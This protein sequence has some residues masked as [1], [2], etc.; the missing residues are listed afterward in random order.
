MSLKINK[1]IGYFIKNSSFK[2]VL[3]VSIE[4]IR[5]IRLDMEKLMFFLKKECE[6]SDFDLFMVKQQ[7]LNS[8]FVI[9]EGKLILS[10]LI[11]P[12]SAGGSN[13]GLFLQDLILYERNRYN[14]LIDYYDEVY[15]K[16]N[17][18]NKNKIFYIDHPLYPH[19]FW[20]ENKTGKKVKFNLNCVQS[21]LLFKKEKLISIGVPEELYFILKFAKIIK[22]NVSY[23]R[24]CQLT[25][26]IM[27]VYFD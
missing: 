21:D 19:D 5:D 25:H 26:T 22:E 13:S 24:V 27:Y 3:N 10:E 20:I 4:D 9:S 23:K 2:E 1:K 16:K 18:K 8:H 14:D 7:I 17:K 15:I 12:I 11:K 6:K